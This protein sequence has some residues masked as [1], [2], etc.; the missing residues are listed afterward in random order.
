MAHIIDIM[1]PGR[2]L[3]ILDRRVSLILPSFPT[4]KTA[5]CPLLLS[6]PLHYLLCWVNGNHGCILNCNRH[7]LHLAVAPALVCASVVINNLLKHAFV[8]SLSLSPFFFQFI[9]NLIDFDDTLLW[10]PDQRRGPLMRVMLLLGEYQS[11][12][13]GE[14]E[15]IRDW[16]GGE[17]ERKST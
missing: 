3:F 13:L 11:S 17:R 5:F 14:T 8:Q 2:S 15:R 6:F 12:F 1:P 10:R 4:Q 7:L 9:S 16:E